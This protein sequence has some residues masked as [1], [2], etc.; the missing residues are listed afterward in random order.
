MLRVHYY[1]DEPN[2]YGYFKEGS[3]GYRFYYPDG[4]SIGWEQVLDREF[5]SLE[6]LTECGSWMPVQKE[7]V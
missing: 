5:F 1:A 4:S 2:A 7:A 6:A 3:F